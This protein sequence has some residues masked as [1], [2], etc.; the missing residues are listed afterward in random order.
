[1]N[2]M[3]PNPLKPGI[4]SVLQTPFS[5]AGGLDFESLGKLIEDSIEAGVDGFLASAV[6]SEV[7]ALGRDERRELVREIARVVDRR[8]PLLVGASSHDPQESQLFAKLAEEVGAGA[9]LVAVPEKLYRQP[10][11]I[12]SFFTQVSSSSELPLLIQDLEWNGP[13]LGLDTI[14]RLKDALPNL[15]GLKIETVPAGAKYTAVRETFG[16]DFFIAGGWA[17]Q[18]WIEALDRGIDALMPESSMIRVYAKILAL[19][20]VGQRDAALK[21]FR[22]LL[23]VL[24]FTNQE[25]NTSIA[26]FKRL[27]VRRGIFK[28]DTMRL[29][30]FGW[31][32]HNSRIAEELIELYLSLEAEVA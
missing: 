17:V 9:F 13:G 15:V 24:A 4:I 23:P 3:E 29:P 26:F 21:L 32:S 1:M 28:H 14:A 20:Q 10:E 31:D 6:A 27:L 12:V 30:G 2:K 25:I 16:A 11:E 5:P 8:V 7:G 19:Y 22:K 18:Q